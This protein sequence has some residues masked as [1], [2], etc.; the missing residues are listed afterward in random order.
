MRHMPGCPTVAQM[1]VD[2]S[3]Y[4]ALSCGGEDVLWN[5]HQLTRFN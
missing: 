3:G 5:L 1:S 4:E 2:D